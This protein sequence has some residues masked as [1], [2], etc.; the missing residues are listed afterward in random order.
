[1][2]AALLYPGIG[3]LEFSISVGRGTDTPF[4][5][6]GAPYVDDVRLS[7]ELNKLGLPGVQF[8]PLRFTPTTSVFKGEACGGVRMAITDRAALRPVEVGIAITCTLQRLYP[9]EFKLALVDTLLNRAVSVQ[10]IRGGEPWKKVVAGWE[11][12][13]QAFAARRKEFLRY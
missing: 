1:L 11:Q 6:L 7:Y 5:V 13:T 2:A 9:K 10:A 8:T 12:E 4:E 3:L